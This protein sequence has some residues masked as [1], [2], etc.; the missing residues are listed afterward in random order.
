LL[1]SL[2]NRVIGRSNGGFTTCLAAHISVQG[3]LTIANAGHLPPYLNG[4]EITVPGSL[5]LGLVADA[6]Y[7]ASTFKLDPG[8]R[9]TFVSDGVPESQ[10][11]SGTLF[12]FDQTRSISRQPAAEIAHAAR[13][14]GQLDDITVVT[15]EFSGAAAAPSAAQ[16]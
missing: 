2:N 4:S 6:R 5:P 14:F 12:G 13:S 10:N 3:T 9:L 16:A 7:E 15:V 11:K 1:D 8:D